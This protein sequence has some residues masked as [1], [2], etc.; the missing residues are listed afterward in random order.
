MYLGIEVNED[1]TFTVAVMDENRNVV[2][3]NHFW[4][5]GLYWFLDHSKIKIVTLNINSSDK[6]HFQIKIKSLIDLKQYLVNQFDFSEFEGKKEEKIVAITDTDRFFEKSIRKKLFPIFTREGLEQRLYNLP[7]SGIV[8]PENLLSL[9]R[10]KLR[11]EV[12]ATVSAFTSFALDKNLFTVE[13][14]EDLLLAVPIYRFIPKE[15]R[16]ISEN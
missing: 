12:N 2:S 15:K 5:E 16:V 8:L 11:R 6:K 4:K 13:E 3:I 1:K 10:R 14:E 9:D 7:K